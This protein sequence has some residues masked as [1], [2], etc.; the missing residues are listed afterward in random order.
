MT[1]LIS[2]LKNNKFHSFWL[3]VSSLLINILALASAF[4]VIQVFNR[5]L[6]SKVDATLT[7]LTIGV[8]IAFTMEFLLRILRGFLVNKVNVVNLRK[9]SSK[10][11]NILLF[12][13]N[14]I[15]QDLNFKK[16]KEYLN[17]LQNSN[18]N[19]AV[20]II[21]SVD[22][23][24]VTIFLTA[25]F[26]LSIKL[27]VVSSLVATIYIMLV[28]FKLK[29]SD[30]F[31]TKKRLYEDSTFSI[32]NDLKTLPRTIRAFNAA[33]LMNKKFRL[34]YARQRSFDKKIKN[35]L[36]II[37]SIN[38]MLPVLSTIGIIYLGA[39]EVS[40]GNLTIGALVGI[41]ILNSRIFNPINQIA[42]FNSYANNEKENF[43]IK[44][45]E[46]ENSEGVKPRMMKGEIKLK[47]LVI[48][49]NRK[50][51]LFQRLNCF[52]PAG[53]VT[54]INGYNSSGKSSLCSSLIGLF[55][56]LKGN[57]LY[58]NIDIKNFNI[59]YLRSNISYLP[60]E[61]ELL[62]ISIKDNITLNLDLK[63]S[64]RNNDGFLLKVMNM[65]GLVNYINNLP[66]GLDTM[67]EN[68]G[69]DI[70][71]GIK[72]RIGL[73]RAIINDGKIIIFDEPT[74][75]LDIEGVK[76]LYKILNDFR[77]LKKTIIIA[78]HDQNII[79]SAG[80]IIDLSTKPIPRIGL[81][82]K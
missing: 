64:S 45:P 80:I 59:K 79:K 20:L 9:F 3:I 78:S 63:S 7:A 72:K 13:K 46:F 12:L 29:F 27:G 75:S 58:D 62:N 23:L 60:Q 32:I 43:F 24:F 10:K 16:N 70:P 5:Y 26:I 1:E 49:F 66:K 74:D 35:F 77:K 18:L 38:V 22:L 65:V 25:I 57:I 55:E 41:N 14:N 61:V 17:P 71:G 53:S 47:D 81:R 30:F 67:V 68:N 37:S 6:S 76:S 52:I 31:S 69:K 44:E 15:K 33:D 54:V 51:I 19:K 82:K 28:L 2:F 34:F 4:Y 8:L 50:N 11:I 40:I 42:L 36:S 21:S 56:P 73:A 39:Q 48:G